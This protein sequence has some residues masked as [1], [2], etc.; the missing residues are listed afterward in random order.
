M[1]NGLLSSL[2]RSL[3]KGVRRRLVVALNQR[4]T[5]AAAAAVFDDRGRVLLLHHRF[6]AGSGWGLPGGFLAAHEQPEAAVRRELREEVGLELDDVEIV[7]VRTLAFANQ[8]EVL[9]RARP[10]GDPTVR[11]R[12]EVDE[13]GW[14]DPGALPDGLSADQRRLVERARNGSV[15][16][17]AGADRGA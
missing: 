1:V 3:P 5:V 17:S 16:P 15:R 13:L 7:L 6:R 8:V 12:F 10:H 4:F 9:F 14:F 11:A 2:W